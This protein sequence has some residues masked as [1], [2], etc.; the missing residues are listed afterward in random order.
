MAQNNDFSGI[1]IQ[2]VT[3]TY[4]M[5]KGR[6]SIRKQWKVIYLSSS[7]TMDIEMYWRKLNG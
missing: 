1:I 7:E 5:F 3:C 6:L 4:M 2:G